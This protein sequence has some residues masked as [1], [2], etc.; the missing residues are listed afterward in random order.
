M[1]QNPEHFA[2]DGTN[3]LLIRIAMDTLE[4]KE[5]FA[6]ILM[7][8]KAFGVT[9]WT[10]ETDGNFVISNYAWTIETNNQGM[11]ISIL[12]KINSEKAFL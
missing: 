10:Q 3:K 12:V 8:V 4:I 5:T 7:E 1:S 9:P 2:R 6:E 11:C